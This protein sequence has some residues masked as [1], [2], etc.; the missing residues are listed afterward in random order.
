MDIEPLRSV[1][2]EDRAPTDAERYAMINV[3]I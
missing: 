1:E 2:R 3:S